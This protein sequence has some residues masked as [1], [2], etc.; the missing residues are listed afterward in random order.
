MRIKGDPIWCKIDGG[1]PYVL[2]Q[3]G[4]KIPH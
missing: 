1:A 2:E 4:D 3:A